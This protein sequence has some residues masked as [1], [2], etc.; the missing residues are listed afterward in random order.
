MDTMQSIALYWVSVGIVLCCVAVLSSKSVVAGDEHGFAAQLAF[1]F[2]LVL[3]PLW[4]VLF[5]YKGW[6]SRH[7]LDPLRH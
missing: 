1:V 3:W 6:R 2:M 7:P 5:M 4:L